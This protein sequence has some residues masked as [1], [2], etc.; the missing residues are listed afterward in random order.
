M[1]HKDIL[2]DIF[3]ALILFLKVRAGVIFDHAILKIHFQIQVL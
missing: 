1:V 3:F 2:F